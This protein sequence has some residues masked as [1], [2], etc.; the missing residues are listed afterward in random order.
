MQD[1][2]YATI[3]SDGRPCKLIDRDQFK[4]N[5][6]TFSDKGSKLKFFNLVHVA[7]MNITVMPT[8]GVNLMKFILQR[9]APFV[10]L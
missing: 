5:I 9:I 1:S 4:I 3:V 6:E 8:D 7:E 2:F 10:N